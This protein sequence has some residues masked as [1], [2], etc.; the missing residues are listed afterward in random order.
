LAAALAPLIVSLLAWAPAARVAA[1]EPS[2]VG[3]EQ[4]RVAIRGI[5]GGVPT[6]IFDRGKTLED[7]AVNAIWIGSGSATRALVTGLKARSPQ[8]KVFAEFNTMHEA[9][10]LKDHADARP[11]GSDGQVAPPPDGWQGVCPTHPGYRSERLDTFRRLVRDVPIDGVWLDYHH[12]QASW[13]QAQPNLPDTCFCERCLEQFQRAT[14][15]SLPA[16]SAAERARRL[17]GSHKKVWVDWRCGVFTDWVREFRAI[18]DQERA[19]ALLG[20]FHCPW[21][22]SDH[23]G[24][25]RQKL[26]I[27]LKSQARFLDVLSIMPYHARF[28]HADDPAWISRQTAWLGRFL[29]IK[30]EPRE[31]LK[32][33]PIVQLSDWGE[34]VSPAQVREVLEQGTR[35]PATGVI[36][37]VW[38]NLH[39]QWDKVER[40]GEFYRQIRGRAE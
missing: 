3:D 14:G 31:R 26:A 11:V 34:P 38:G 10:Y 28:G 13:E 27:D 1:G 36:V 4:P 17:L 8:V 22:E 32:I 21:S 2:A 19:G 29:Q 20:T 40:M 15:L 37:F 16:S 33:W 7:Y 6:Q 23:D 35:P 25:L 9:G 5:Y 12:A 39:P 24:A 18:I 30:G